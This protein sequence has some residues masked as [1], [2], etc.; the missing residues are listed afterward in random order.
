MS[1][2]GKWELAFWIVTIICGIW[3][4][5]ITEGVIANDRL[6]ACEDKALGVEIRDIKDMIFD[7][8]LGIDRRLYRIEAKLGVDG[9]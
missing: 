4:L 1:G 6:R 9:K 3:L 2:N 7:K 5:A 8:L